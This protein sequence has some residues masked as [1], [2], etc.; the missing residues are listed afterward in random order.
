MTT[1]VLFPSWRFHVSQ[2]TQRFPD[3]LVKSQDEADK[4]GPDWT[5]GDTAPVS[6]DDALEPGTP[7]ETA[8]KV[9]YPSWRYHPSGAKRIVETAAEDAALGEGWSNG[10]DLP[11]PMDAGTTADTTVP[12]NDDVLRT[13]GPTLEDYVAAGYR[14]EDYPPPGYAE[15]PSEGLTAFRSQQTGEGPTDAID[16]TAEFHAILAGTVADVKAA[17]PDL[18]PEALSALR[19][20]EVNGKDRAGVL[21]A[22]DD[23][24]SGQ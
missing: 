13:D 2:D 4:L 23:R 22:I 12:V 6:S 20:L 11:D 7:P 16:R 14:A 17:L 8:P 3:R 1:R 5:N 18:S 19:L 10:D 21:G 15:V 9:L 24:L